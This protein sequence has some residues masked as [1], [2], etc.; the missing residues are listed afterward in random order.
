VSPVRFHERA[1]LGRPRGT[2]L[3]AAS[4]AVL[5]LEQSSMRRPTKVRRPLDSSIVRAA[6]KAYLE[7]SRKAR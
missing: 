7:G 4:N 1:R 2:F 3:H 5:F 6:L